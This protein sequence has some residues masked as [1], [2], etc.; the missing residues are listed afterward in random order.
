MSNFLTETAKPR[1]TQIVS[2]LA[3]LIFMPLLLL[4]NSG[5]RIP[6]NAGIGNSCKY[7]HKYEISTGT[8]EFGFLPCIRPGW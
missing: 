4:G 3:L 5:S 2:I 8:T 1:I 6:H 7:C